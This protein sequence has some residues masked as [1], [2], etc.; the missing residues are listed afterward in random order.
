[1]PIKLTQITASRMEF[2]IENNKQGCSFIREIRVQHKNSLM[3]TGHFDFNKKYIE[4][5]KIMQL[6][7]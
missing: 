3:L 5:A 2:L 7:K 6:R 1:M 4:G